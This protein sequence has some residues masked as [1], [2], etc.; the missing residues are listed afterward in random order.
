MTGRVEIGCSHGMNGN[1][2]HSNI[3]STNPVNLSAPIHGGQILPELYLSTSSSRE[4]SA[5]HF[6][7]DL[8]EHLQLKSVDKRLKWTLMSNSL[9]EKFSKNWFMATKEHIN[10]Y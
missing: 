6:L 4:Q 7:E 9:T 8:D 10:S 1:V 5:V 2:L 3:C